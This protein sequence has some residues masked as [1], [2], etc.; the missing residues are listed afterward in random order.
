[1][2]MAMT[3]DVTNNQVPGV[4]I[5]AQFW[6]GSEGHPGSLSSLPGVHH[7]DYFLETCAK[8]VCR[9]SWMFGAVSV[10]AQRN[11]R[12]D[13][14]YAALHSLYPNTSQT[15]SPWQAA[16]AFSCSLNDSPK[17]PELSRK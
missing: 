1:M 8:I 6:E 12:S 15:H 3:Q 5:S 2:N 10:I 13:K 16:V 11:R 14:I 4:G 17:N 9:R 7:D